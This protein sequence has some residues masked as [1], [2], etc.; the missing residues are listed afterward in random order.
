LAAEPLLFWAEGQV[1]VFV[2]VTQDFVFSQAVREI[3]FLLPA[4]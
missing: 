4:Q 2:Q 1:I 3:A